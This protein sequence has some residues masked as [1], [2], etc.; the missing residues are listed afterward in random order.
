MEWNALPGGCFVSAGRTRGACNACVLRGGRVRVAHTRVGRR[1]WVGPRVY[2]VHAVLLED[3][4]LR[5][6]AE[7]G[8][9]GM[10]HV[11]GD[12][13]P[14]VVQRH[15]EYGRHLGR[16]HRKGQMRCFPESSH[17]RIT[18]RLPRVTWPTGDD[19]RERGIATGFSRRTGRVT[20]QPRRVWSGRQLITSWVA[21]FPRPRPFHQFPG[22][23]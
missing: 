18:R 17:R 11:D 3:D 12:V 1:G 19:R 9:D 21:P 20:P 6:G 8:D 23:L 13:E 16:A 10:Q 4:H 15:Q 14:H 7:H 22:T 2:L 5:H